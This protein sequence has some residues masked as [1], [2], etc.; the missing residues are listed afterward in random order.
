MH[1]MATIAFIGL[2]NMGRPMAA[3]QVRAGNEVIGFDVSP[4]AV[5][6][7][8]GDGVRPAGSIAEAVRDADVVISM[9]PKG[10]QAR[11]VYLGEGGILANAK[12]GAVLIDSSTIDVATAGQLHEAAHADL[13][14]RF[15]FV[16]APVS[17][18]ISGAAAGT[19]TFMVGGEPDAVQVA[20]PVL[21]PMA[22]NVIATGGPT[23][24][25]AA[26]ICNNMMLFINLQ[27]CAEGSVLARKL[28]LDDK[29][30]HDIA[31]VSSGNSWALQTWY[32]VPD[33]IET[34]AANNDFAATFRADLA[35]KDIGLAL[36]GAEQVG[37]S[38]PAA[39]LVAEQL[40]NI[41]RSGDGD[42][43]C[44]VIV[45]NIDPDAPGLPDAAESTPNTNP[46]EKQ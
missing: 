16:D 8:E 2:G 46:K 4:A 21:E 30:F 36:S 7:A 22:G 38:L 39:E 12:P 13:D 9:V 34:A 5:R 20:T 14:K 45:R 1:I 10:D 31:K 23:T 26:K 32:P 44:S 37:L 15:T 40:D 25:Q 6:A 35:A 28:G 41:I 43:D 27:A 24:G 29:V 3:N 42:L 11:E 17:G 18:G 19:L 33:I